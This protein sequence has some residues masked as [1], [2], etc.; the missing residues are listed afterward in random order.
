ML[1]YRLWMEIIDIGVV[2]IL[3][4][5]LHVEISV[6]RSLF[7]TSVCTA[8]MKNRIGRCLSIPNK[9]LSSQIGIQSEN[10]PFCLK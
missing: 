2:N 5:S 6:Y 1:C 9:K 4:I 7:S 10:S 3:R 8:E